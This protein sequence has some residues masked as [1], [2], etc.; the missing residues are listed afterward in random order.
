MLAAR[1]AEQD[2]VGLSDSDAAARLNEPDPAFPP[3]ES[4][5][6]TK[7]G[8]GSILD[9]LG[10]TKGAQFLDTLEELAKTTPV[11]RWALELIRGSGLDLSRV[12]AHEQL[13]LLVDWKV[14]EPSDADALFALSRRVTP[15]SWAEAHMMR[16]DARAV[17]IARG[18]R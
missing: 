5:V 12:S 14:L 15:V 6:E 4:W 1:L 8:I 17:G 11:I 7:I 18:G 9:T 16:V 13:L 2:M 10:P 3:I